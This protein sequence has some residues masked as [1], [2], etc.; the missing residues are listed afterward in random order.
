MKYSEFIDWLV[1]ERSKIRIERLPA[2]RVAQSDLIWSLK[3]KVEAIDKWEATQQKHRGK[4]QE[5]GAG[6]QESRQKLELAKQELA[7]LNKQLEGPAKSRAM[8]R[9]ELK[10]L[11]RQ[12]DDNCK[13]LEAEIEER[14]GSIERIRTALDNLANGGVERMERQRQELEAELARV[15]EDLNAREARAAELH[16]MSVARFGQERQ[17][18]LDWWAEKSPVLLSIVEELTRDL[19]T[20]RKLRGEVIEALKRQQP[21]VA[22]GLLENGRQ[23]AASAK[24]LSRKA[25]VCREGLEWASVM[26]DQRNLNASHLFL[27]SGDIREFE[28]LT[29]KVYGIFRTIVL[30]STSAERLA[31]EIQE[32][33]A[34]LAILAETQAFDADT[35]KRL[36]KLACEQLNA[37][38]TNANNQLI[39]GWPKVVQQDGAAIASMIDT[40]KQDPGT[41]FRSAAKSYEQ[42]TTLV[43]AALDTMRT[44]MGEVSRKVEFQLGRIPRD[45]AVSCRDDLKAVNAIRMSAKETLAEF[46]KKHAAVMLLVKQLG[47]TLQQQL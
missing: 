29:K 10:T 21:E 35:V 17:G 31:V 37:L 33:V 16:A 34:Q 44:V 41:H 15:S 9:S 32:E 2:D 13:R 30:E 24:T 22:A 3:L 20:V 27:D 38:L 47:E 43:P 12:Q 19:D 8:S 5:L 46:E 42:A 40:L 7:A 1:A 39:I 26:D 18:F 45:L 25:S 14:Q 11:A 4:I 28:G 6:I 23:L 36:L